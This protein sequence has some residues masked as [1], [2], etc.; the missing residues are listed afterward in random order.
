VTAELVLVL[1][2]VFLVLTLVFA[3]MSLQVQRMYL[4]SA[5]SELAR[6]I[7]REESI[8]FVDGLVAGL[9]EYVGFEIEEGEGLVCVTLKSKVEILSLDMGGLELVETQCAKAQGL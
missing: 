5:A 7:A 3:V 4:V 8:G 1:P 9:K 2:A 6:A